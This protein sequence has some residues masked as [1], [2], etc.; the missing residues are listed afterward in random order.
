LGAE[1]LE[2]VKECMSS[3][4]SCKDKEDN[5]DTGSKKRH[6]KDK[7]VL[8][9]VTISKRSCKDKEDNEDTGSKKRHHKDKEVLKVVTMKL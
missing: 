3:K 5:E 9:V 4:R 1:M 2:T 6:H 8:K 7:E